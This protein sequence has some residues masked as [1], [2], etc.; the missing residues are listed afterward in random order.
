MCGACVPT[1]KPEILKN[2]GATA[3]VD[4]HNALGA[5]VGNF[6]MKLAIQKAKEYGVGWVAAK[7]EF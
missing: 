7:R 1:A 5:T 2:Q 4:G 3:W 6:C